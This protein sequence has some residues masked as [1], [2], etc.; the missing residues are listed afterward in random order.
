MQYSTEN[1]N[2]WSELCQK[3]IGHKKYFKL[4]TIFVTI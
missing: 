1:E 4:M 3:L 2:R